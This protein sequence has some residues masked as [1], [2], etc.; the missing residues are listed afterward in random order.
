[1]LLLI[2]KN[3]TNLTRKTIV[4]ILLKSKSLNLFKKNPQ[5]YM[6]QVAQIITAKMRLLMIVDGIKY[7]KI[8]NDEYYAQ[9]LLE[10]RGRNL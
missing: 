4:D 9:E 2:F 8:G 5:R 3:E 6:E 1:M 10:S 7:T